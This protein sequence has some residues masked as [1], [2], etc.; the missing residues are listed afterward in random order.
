TGAPGGIPGATSSREM[1]RRKCWNKPWSDLTER[2]EIVAVC[3]KG[4]HRQRIRL[5]D[6][7]LP[8]PPPAGAE[9]IAAYRYWAGF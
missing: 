1:R 6:L 5:L 4:N 2:D 8:S 3:R 7:P 9:W